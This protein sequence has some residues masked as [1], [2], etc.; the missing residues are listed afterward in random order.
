[1]K[2][3]FRALLCGSLLALT[4]LRA[5]EMVLSEFMAGNGRTLADED[6]DSSNWIEIH[7]GGAGAV[8]L[9]GWFLTDEQNRPAKWRFPAVALA[10]GQSQLV[11]A[12]AKHRT[13]SCAYRLLTPRQP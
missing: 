5:A 7:N 10:A 13:N 4:P 12:S 9:A 3:L 1:M 2:S 11:W 8:N 6:G